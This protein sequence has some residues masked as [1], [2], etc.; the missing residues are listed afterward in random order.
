MTDKHISEVIRRERLARGWTV[1]E[2]AE[3]IDVDQSAWSRWEAGTTTPR[4]STLRHLAAL[5]DLPG[6]WATVEHP[7]TTLDVNQR[8]ERL[9]ERLTAALHGLEVEA[10]RIQQLADKMMGE[11][12]DDDRGPGGGRQA[13]RDPDRPR[14]RS[15]R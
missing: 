6:D 8:L 1:T 2:A 5:F 9:E 4:P 12:R 14:S 3:R 7:S 11:L 13:D 10:E 15:D